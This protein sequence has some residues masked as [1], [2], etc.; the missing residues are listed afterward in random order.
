MHVRVCRD[1]GEEYRPEIASCAD[2]GGTLE[3]RYEPELDE[4]VTSPPPARQTAP[5]EVPDRRGYCPIYSTDQAPALVP[6]ADR[7]RERGIAFQLAEKAG[8]TRRVAARYYLLIPVQVAAEAWRELAPL[9]GEGEGASAP[10]NQAELADGAEPSCPACGAELPGTPLEC[11][12]C[13]IALGE[14]EEA[15]ANGPA[16]PCARCGLLLRPGQTE[17]PLCGPA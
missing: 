15:Q 7:L 6:L 14:P 4:A 2:C 11:P 8:G 1:C 10:G 13:G 12:G 17:C 9:L 3:D 5:P 16:T